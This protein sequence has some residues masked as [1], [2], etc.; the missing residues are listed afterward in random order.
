M[1]SGASEKGP[2]LPPSTGPD[3]GTSMGLDDDADRDGVPDGSDN[4]PTVGNVSQE[5]RDLDGT[6]D[7]CDCDADDGEVAG[8]LIVGDSLGTDRGLTA[9]VP[10]FPLASW[11]HSGTALE[12]GE[13][14]D[15][16]ADALQITD[17]M[18]GDL[19]VD[20][21][22]ASTDI[23]DFGA[24]DLRQLFIVVGAGTPFSAH[25]CGIEI[26]EG[27]TPTQRT[28]IVVLD[29]AGTPVTSALDR[30]SRSA[31]QE[32]EELAMSMSYRGGELTCTVTLGGGEV[33]VARV[34]GIELGGPVGFF[35]RETRALFRDL[36][37][38]GTIASP[39]N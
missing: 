14:A 35:T 2:M 36:R 39:V 22:V 8:E 13:L 9:A 29:G 17:A 37:V 10:G 38:C 6:G 25:G 5:D 11:S 16:R 1:A 26:V 34:S 27:M 15:D 32:N 18:V 3:S 28:S 4:C 30:V 20:V 33:S 21:T 23:Q 12:Q 19:R 7:G 24:D 31:V